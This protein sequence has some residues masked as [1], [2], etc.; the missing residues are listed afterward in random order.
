[1]QMLLKQLSGRYG[2]A[3]FSHLGA[4]ELQVSMGMAP[5]AL[6]GLGGDP[7]LKQLLRNVAVLY[8][9]MD[10]MCII[11]SVSQ[12]GG[13]ASP[14]WMLTGDGQ[15]LML[16]ASGP[17][18]SY[19]SLCRQVLQILKSLICRLP[20]TVCGAEPIRRNSKRVGT[21]TLSNF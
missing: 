20:S 18:T 10:F 16:V 15:G 6:C 11:T 19:G 4:A 1:M 3:L 9:C 12:Y 8:V 5:D 14:S 13:A 21:T 2:I 7:A 17:Y